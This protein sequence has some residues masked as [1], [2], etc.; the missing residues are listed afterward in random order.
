MLFRK[1]VLCDLQP[2]VCSFENCKTAGKVYS[3]RRAWFKHE[4]KRHRNS[5]KYHCQLRTCK[6][7]FGSGPAFRKHLGKSHGLAKWE[8][9]DLN[10][11]DVKRTT[12]AKH[13]SYCTFCDMHLGDEASIPRH[14]G[15]HLEELAFVILAKQ[16]QEWEFYEES[17]TGTAIS[18][19][20][21]KHCRDIRQAILNGDVETLVEFQEHGYD[22]MSFQD[23]I[24]QAWERACSE[25]KQMF[26]WYLLRHGVRPPSASILW[27]AR[28]RDVEMIAL[29]LQAD[30]EID[31]SFL[32]SVLARG[33][34]E[35]AEI[36]IKASQQVERPL[37]LNNVLGVFVKRDAVT[38]GIVDRL[39]EFIPAT[40]DMVGNYTDAFYR[41]VRAQNYE[42]TKLFLGF[43][44]STWPD[45]LVRALEIVLEDQIDWEGSQFTPPEPGSN[46]ALIA[47]ALADHASRVVS[48]QDT[49]TTAMHIAAFDGHTATVHYLLHAG[50][51]PNEADWAHR[52]PLH[53]AIAGGHPRIGR[54]LLASG[55]EIEIRTGGEQPVS[56]YANAKGYWAADLVNDF[57]TR[58]LSVEGDSHRSRCS[59][60]ADE[61]SLP[62]GR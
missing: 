26:V 37:D 18:S 35:M 22:I 6:G 4:L 23:A 57:K 15:R 24:G 60:C 46:T 42:L 50:C 2:Y 58:G 39:L 36:L 5:I 10:M 20:S 9:V 12:K 44:Q 43:S 21:S 62:P 13:Y 8:I 59:G 16:Y 27:A 55:A 45:R 31:P 19:H 61:A 41:T 51:N 17:S 29:L 28:A 53:R 32:S 52:Y 25:G 38:P 49:K 48:Q 3:T 56:Q 54:L 47:S 14:V 11:K 1:H 34:Y 33:D 7:E 30:L 40:T